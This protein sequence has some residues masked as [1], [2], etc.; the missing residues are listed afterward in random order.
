MFETHYRT[1]FSPENRRQ[2]AQQHKVMYRGFDIFTLAVMEKKFAEYFITVKQY[3][4]PRLGW[5]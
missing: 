4:W 2:Y 5:D 1:A 3:F